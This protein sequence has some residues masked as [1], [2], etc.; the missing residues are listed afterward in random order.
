M[1]VRNDGIEEIEAT[2]LEFGRNVGVLGRPKRPEDVPAQGD[3]RRRKR[4]ERG[5]DRR[6]RYALRFTESTPLLTERVK[7]RLW[8][9][10]EYERKKNALLKYANYCLYAKARQYVKMIY[11]WQIEE[12]R[13]RAI[14]TEPGKILRHGEKLM[15]WVESQKKDLDAN[16]WRNKFEECKKLKRRKAARA[17]AGRQEEADGRE[18]G[19]EQG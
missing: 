9:K 10:I 11:R 13:Q 14:V 12:M 17:R 1:S 3:G 18:P 5:P 2:L 4:G 8:D 7:N 16:L 19:A 15:K 6:P